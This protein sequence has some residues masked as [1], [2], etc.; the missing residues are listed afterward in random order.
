MDTSRKTALAAVAV[1]VL[2]VLGVLGVIGSATPAQAN[3]FGDYWNE[4]NFQRYWYEDSSLNDDWQ[5]QA[6]WVRRNDIDPTD[7][8][9]DERQI[10][11]NSDVSVY[12]RQLVDD[13]AVADATCIS[14]TGSICKHWHVRVNTTWEPFSQIDKRHILCHEF[15]H[16]LGLHHYADS[17]ETTSCM[18]VPGAMYYAN[19]DTAHV[20]DYYPTNPVG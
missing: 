4:S 16:T 15:G 3:P 8:F 20:N 6:N 2:G 12:R 17:V 7:M 5:S 18:K 1:H 13:T 11:D 14:W 9:S 10:H 19:H